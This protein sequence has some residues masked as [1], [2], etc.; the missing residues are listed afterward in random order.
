VVDEKLV[1]ENP[2]RITQL[3]SESNYGEHSILVYPDLDTFR[4][5]Y[6]H[7]I[8]AR[9]QNNDIVALLP[10]YETLSSIKINLRELDMDITAL[11]NEKKLLVIDSA[12]VFFTNLGFSAFAMGLEDLAKRSGRNGTFIF[13][14]MGPFFHRDKIQELLTWENSIPTKNDMKCSLICCYHEKDL[15]RLSEDQKKML[16][17]HHFTDLHVKNEETNTFRR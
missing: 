10:H 13:A 11:Q 6:T 8:Q 3:L 7:E 12:E 1:I 17:N 9:I 4:E 14:E 5:V 2:D 15:Q 16:C